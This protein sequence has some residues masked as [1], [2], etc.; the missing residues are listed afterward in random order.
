MQ[1]HRGTNVT[2]HAIKAIA[3]RKL[4]CN[5]ALYNKM[6][7]TMCDRLGVGK[8]QK[9][10]ARQRFFSGDRLMAKVKAQ[11]IAGRFAYDP[12]QDER[13]MEKIE[14]RKTVTVTEIP[15][16]AGTGAAFHSNVL[17]MD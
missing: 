11:A 10:N 2:R 14:V 8:V 5:R 7:F 16:H 4:L 13:R 12:G 6:L 17:R 3:N 9:F 1:G 15:K